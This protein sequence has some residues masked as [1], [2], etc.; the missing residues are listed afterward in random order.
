[1]TDRLVRTHIT[2]ALHSTH[3]IDCPQEFDGSHMAYLVQLA[4]NALTD[5]EYISPGISF[6]LRQAAAQEALLAMRRRAIRMPSDRSERKIGRRIT[7][8][9]SGTLYHAPL[10]HRRIALDPRAA[11]E[12]LVSIEDGILKVVALSGEVL[13]FSLDM[14]DGW[15][16]D[17]SWAYRLG[18]CEDGPDGRDEASIL[19]DIDRILQLPDGIHTLLSQRGFY[20]RKNYDLHGIRKD[21][22]TALL[23]E[24]WRVVERENPSMEVVSRRIQ[25]IPVEQNIS[26]TYSGPFAMIAD[27]ATL[28]DSVL[29]DD[30]WVRFLKEDGLPFMVKCS[31]IQECQ[32]QEVRSTLKGTDIGACSNPSITVLD[33][34]KF[35]G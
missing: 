6:G 17:D 5:M 15:R 14:L 20:T 12:S 10:Q 35:Q 11:T 30:G 2:P 28:E 27:N 9:L 33:T 1:M 22:L 4:C 7:L 18:E 24:Y 34:Y 23:A 29:E 19:N 3:I 13:S 21:P 25:I 8:M 16:I 31:A 26:K 32:L